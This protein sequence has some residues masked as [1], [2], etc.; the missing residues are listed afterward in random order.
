M[1]VVRKSITA[2]VLALTVAG[3]MAATA[4]PAAAGTISKVGSVRD[5]GCYGSRLEVEPIM[6]GNVRLG[7]VELWY[8]RANGGT[9]CVLTRNGTGSPATMAELWVDRDGNKRLTRG[10]G[11]SKDYGTYPNYAGGAYQTRTDR[12]C[13][14]F[15]GSIKVGGVEYWNSSGGWVHCR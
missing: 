15:Y 10:D 11:Y 13:V 2:A 5:A 8:S 1:S 7:Q 6:K 4:A 12:K 14:W 3:G 9:N